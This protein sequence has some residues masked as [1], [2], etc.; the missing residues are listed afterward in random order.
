MPLIDL[1]VPDIGDLRDVRVLEILVKPGDL[2]AVWNGRE[3]TP[4]LTLPLSLSYDHRVNDGVTAA[5]FNGHLTRVLSD[6]R[7]TTL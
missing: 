3:F 1:S 6:F 2:E 5:R 7:R 4:R